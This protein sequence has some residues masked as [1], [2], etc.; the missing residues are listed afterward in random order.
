[1]KHLIEI[2]GNSID[3]NLYQSKEF[4]KLQIDSC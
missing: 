2:F 4:K 1:M 3:I